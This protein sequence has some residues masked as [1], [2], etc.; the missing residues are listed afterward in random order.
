MSANPETK[1]SPDSQNQMPLPRTDMFTPSYIHTSRNSETSALRARTEH[2]RA[3]SA[4][5]AHQTSHWP[6]KQATMTSTYVQRDKLRTWSK[7]LD[8]LRTWSKMRV[9][10]IYYVFDCLRGLSDGTYTSLP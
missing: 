7:I 8:K 4:A 6:R 10:G 5:T 9:G 3:G 1:T 2:K